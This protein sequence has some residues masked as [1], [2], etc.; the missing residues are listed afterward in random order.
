[1]RKERG[2][3]PDF[4]SECD[5]CEQ[6]WPVLNMLPVGVKVVGEERE[7]VF[8][9]DGCAGQLGY[10]CWEHET[11]HLGF[12]DGTTACRVCIDTKVAEEGNAIAG[13]LSGDSCRFAWLGFVCC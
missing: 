3:N 10:F 13:S 8:G 2:E 9:C 11:V 5:I 7:A 4:L 1:M 6:E 12:I